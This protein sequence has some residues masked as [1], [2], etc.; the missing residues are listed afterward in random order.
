MKR[1]LFKEFYLSAHPTAYIFTALGVLVLVPNYPYGVIFLFGGL[2]SMITFSYGRETNDAA[3]SALLPVSRRRIVGGRLAFVC[4]AQVCQLLLSLPFAFLRTRLFPGGNAAGIEANAAFYGFAM[5]AYAL[6][7]LV[8]F[9]EFYKT[10]HRVGA[11]FLKAVLPI[12][13]VIVCMET[14]AHIPALAFFDG[15]SAH[16]LLLQTPLFAFG[17]AAYVICNVFAYRI[18][19]ARF[20]RIDH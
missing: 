7:N 16:D 17:A 4:L 3:F 9:A 14:C 5:L 20:A 19:S 15:V 11:S 10:G 2:A 1:L 12:V 18:A 8:F 6:Y 13:L